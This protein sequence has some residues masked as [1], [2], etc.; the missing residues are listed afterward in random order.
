VID[1][2]IPRIHEE[3]VARARQCLNDLIPEQAST[4]CTW[5][6]PSSKVGHIERYSVKPRRGA[7]T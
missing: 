7:R 4:Y 5:K 3:A 1:V 6:S 2:D